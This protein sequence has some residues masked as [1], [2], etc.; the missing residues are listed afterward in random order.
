MDTSSDLSSMVRL[1]IGGKKF[2][3]TIDTLTNREP[4][5]ML[6]A[7]FSGRHAMA[8]ESKTGYVFIDRDG[9]HFRHI[10][11]WLRDGIA[12]TLSDPDCSEL[13]RETDYYQLLGLKEILKASRRETG[14]VE[15]E[16][17]RV[18][19]IKCIQSERVRFRGVNLSGIDLSKLVTF[20]KLRFL[21]L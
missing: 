10:L 1:N 6:S 13:L 4:D 12:P 20:L 17:T 19:I 14:E 2:C 8:H 7:M 11:N 15:A 3:T 18:D 5:S 16:L 21:Y 9:K